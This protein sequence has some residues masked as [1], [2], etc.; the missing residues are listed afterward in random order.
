MI[1]LRT[2]TFAQRRIYADLFSLECSAFTGVSSDTGLEALSHP[3]T[4]QFELAVVTTATIFLF[5]IEFVRL[6]LDFS[7][8]CSNL[9]GTL[10]GPIFFCTPSFR[11]AK[12]RDVSAIY[13]DLLYFGMMPLFPPVGPCIPGISL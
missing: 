5:A 6:R 3:L 10:N 1:I 13:S 7:Y 4:F 12:R 2:N 8:P 9:I 11:K